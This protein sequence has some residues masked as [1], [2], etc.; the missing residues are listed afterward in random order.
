V[1]TAGAQGGASGTAAAGAEFS[2]DWPAGKSGYTVLLQSL[3]Q[4]ATTTATVSQAKSTASAK[5]APA[6]GAL[7]SEDFTSLPAGS[8]DVYSGEYAS[9]AQAE[10]ALAKL[11]KSF[12]GASVIR[13][14]AAGGG[15]GGRPSGGTG[16]GVGSGARSGSSAS[17]SSSQLQ[18]LSKT[19]GRSYEQE[20][21]NLPN[22]V[23]T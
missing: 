23:G 20:S 16:P 15:S 22:E 6:V 12:P 9:K 2:D 13:V 10:R 3:P 4:A 11:R 21:K 7:K 8:Y 14:S 19:R 18:K 1:I 5:G 17:G